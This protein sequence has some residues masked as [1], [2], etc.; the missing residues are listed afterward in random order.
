MKN[1]R[2]RFATFLALSLLLTLAACTATK[3]A[4]NPKLVVLGHAGSGFFTPISPFNFRPPS[5]WRGIRHALK[6]GADGV[7]IDL[8]LSRD[9]VVMLYHDQ[10]LENISTGQGCVSQRTAAELTQLR[11][12]GGFPYDLLQKERPVTF[13]TLLARLNRRASFPF[14]HLDLHEDDQ[15]LPPGQQRG[16]SAAILRQIARSLAR[17]HVPPEKMLLITQEETTIPLARAILPRVRVGLEIAS[18]EFD[19]GLRLARAQRVHTVVLDA[20]RVTP[21]QAAQAHAA[22]LAVVVFG[23]RSGKDIARVLATQPDEV[24][25]DNTKRLLIM[26]GRRKK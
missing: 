23:G 26:Q 25:V 8:Q 9:S 20:D 16:Q 10:K 1:Y 7:E 18:A 21:D 4:I 14:L 22:G 12:R 3:P 6:L 2:L 15:C 19:K 5:S 24:E 17:Y 11:Y 13:D